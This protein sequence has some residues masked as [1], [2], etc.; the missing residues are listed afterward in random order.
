[1]I[2]HGLSQLI[3]EASINTDYFNKIPTFVKIPSLLTL[4]NHIL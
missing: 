2:N 4:D 3:S 1:M